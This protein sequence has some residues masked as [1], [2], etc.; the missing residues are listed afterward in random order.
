LF[1]TKILQKFDFSVSPISLIY[2][3]ILVIDVP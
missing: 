2:G 3:D 1:K